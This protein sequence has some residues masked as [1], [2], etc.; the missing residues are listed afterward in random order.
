MAGRLNESEVKEFRFKMTCPKLEEM[1]RQTEENRKHQG[2][3]YRTKT[4]LLRV[5]LVID[6]EAKLSL[7]RL[8]QNGK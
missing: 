2:R 7:T 3:N 5:N 4:E 8:S 1:L 6:R